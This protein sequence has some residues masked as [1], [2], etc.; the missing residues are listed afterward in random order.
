MDYVTADTGILI[1]PTS[2]DK[3]IFE[4]SDAFRRLALSPE[5][6]RRMGEAGR[7]RIEEHFDWQR[8]IDQI[9]GIYQKV[10]DR[11]NCQIAGE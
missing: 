4:F 10:I 7:L 6:R 5:L 8:K 1:E 11:T 3:V 2:R 9:I